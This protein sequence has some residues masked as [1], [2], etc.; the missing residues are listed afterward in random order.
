MKPIKLLAMASG[1]AAL[2]AFDVVNLQAGSAL[3]NSGRAAW[4][5]IRS[6]TDLAAIDGSVS[7]RWPQMIRLPLVC[8]VRAR[9]TRSVVIFWR[10]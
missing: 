10:P 1:I 5:S 8:P 3:W 2:V 7:C 4:H 6:A 9:G